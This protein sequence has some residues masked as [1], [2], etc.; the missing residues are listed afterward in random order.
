MAKIKVM[1]IVH[2]LGVGGVED[3]GDQ[4]E[5]EFFDPCDHSLANLAGLSEQFVLE[6]QVELLEISAPPSLRCGI[7]NHL[8]PKRLRHPLAGH[9]DE[10]ALIIQHG[11]AVVVDLQ[12]P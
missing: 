8:L 2:S 4:V 3:V 11:I 10:A 1:Y 5:G 7:G 9:L 6:G 12:A